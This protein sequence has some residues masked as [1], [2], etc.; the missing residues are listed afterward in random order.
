M[1]GT[2][3]PDQAET[4]ALLAELRHDWIRVATRQNQ[5][6]AP[7][8]R[9]PVA[10]GAKPNPWCRGQGHFPKLRPGENVWFCVKAVGT[11]ENGWPYLVVFVDH[12]DSDFDE[13]YEYR[14]W[15][16]QITY[17]LRQQS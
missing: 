15:P 17:E 16:E 10:D 14:L 7:H 1:P 12:P 4:L 8:W 5:A 9:L 6:M 11:C 3:R 2:A 13:H